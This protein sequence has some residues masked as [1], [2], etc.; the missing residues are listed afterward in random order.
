M[1]KAILNIGLDVNGV[2]KHTIGT[3]AHV[4]ERYVPVISIELAQ[5]ATE[6]TAVVVIEHP[7]AFAR[8]YYLSKD[9]QQDAIAHLHE[10]KGKLVGPKA[11]E[12]GA[13]DPQ[14]FL[15]PD[16]KIIVDLL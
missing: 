4:V 3:V 10:G 5:S 1:T 15:L 8:L 11:A 13:F 12:W 7:L 9:L 2:R 14:Y 6:M 16:S